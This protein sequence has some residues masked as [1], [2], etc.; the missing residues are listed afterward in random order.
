VLAIIVLGV[1]F[2]ISW[3]SGY[4]YLPF[5]PQ[6]VVMLTMVVFCLTMM[7]SVTTT[8]AGTGFIARQDHS[9]VPGTP[10]GDVLS[11]VVRNTTDAEERIFQAHPNSSIR[12]VLEEDW[13]FKHRPTNEW[14]LID[15]NGND[16][17]DWPISNWEGVATL[18]YRD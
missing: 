12:E 3:L 9:T 16:V 10:R 5:L 1:G 11:R 14:Y 8:M 13:P 7:L 4:G 17:T 15:E 2:S 18:R 6:T